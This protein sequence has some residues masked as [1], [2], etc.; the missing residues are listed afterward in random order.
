MNI[1][2]FLIGIQ[3]F[4]EVSDV[5][6]GEPD[7]PDFVMFAASKRVGIEM[8]ALNRRSF[9]SGDP[10]HGEFRKWENQTKRKPEPMHVFHWGEYRL[11]EVLAMFRRRLAEKAA[12]AST[13]KQPFPTRFWIELIGFP[14]FVGIIVVPKVIWM[15]G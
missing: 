6:Y 12:K 2:P 8:T 3:D 5:I 9:Q 13:Q 4:V 1:Y 11:R 7:P 15:R 14:Q 10:R